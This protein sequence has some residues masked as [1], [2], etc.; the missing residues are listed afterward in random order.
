MRRVSI[1]PAQVRRRPHRPLPSLADLPAMWIS[2]VPRKR[3]LGV[4]PARTTR[5]AAPPMSSYPYRSIMTRLLR[6]AGANRRCKN[7]RNACRAISLQYPRT[8]AA[9]V[10]HDVRLA[11]TDTSLRQP[12]CSS[13]ASVRRCRRLKT[14]T[15]A[16]CSI[17]HTPLLP[18]TSYDLP[19]TSGVMPGPTPCAPL[20]AAAH[21]ERCQPS[22][23]LVL[24]NRLRH[25]FNTL[26]GCDGWLAF[27]D[28][29][30]VFDA[31]VRAAQGSPGG[32]GG[33]MSDLSVD[34]ALA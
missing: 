3:S 6:T 19:A 33:G 20:Q 28:R 34:R 26:G 21:T 12:R 32:A 25:P 11:N 1:E 4:V 5:R 18:A 13:A 15:S 2:A 16:S 17:L 29:E 14:T 8:D 7:L 23:C 31:C 9:I 24:P 30:S 10:T 27:L 22:A